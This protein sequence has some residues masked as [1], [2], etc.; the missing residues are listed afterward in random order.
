M[1]AD[2]VDLSPHDEDD[3]TQ[4]TYTVS[5]GQITLSTTVSEAIIGLPY[6]GRWK[7]TKLAYGATATALAQVKKVGRVGFIGRNLHA[8]GIRFGQDFTDMDP[9]PLIEDGQ[10]VDV[11]TVHSSYDEPTIDFDGI[12]DTDP[13]ICVE[14]YSPRPAT[15]MAVIVGLDT[16]E[17][18]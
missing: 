7:S 11:D 3:W 9:L 10:A 12:S 16:N 2:G 6:Q 17:K 8:R 1:W 4:T 14:F 15:L 13:R 5:S 18:A